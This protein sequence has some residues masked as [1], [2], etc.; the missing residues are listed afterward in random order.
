[1]VIENRIIERITKAEM[2]EGAIVSYKNCVIGALDLIGVFKLGSQ[3]SLENCIVQNLLI[4]S[5]WFDQGFSMKNCVVLRE[6][7]FQMGGHNAQPIIFDGNI[8]MEF[9][10]FFDCQF[11]EMIE[12]KHNIFMKG[13]NFLGNK[14]EGYEN[15]F[16]SG[17]LA[18]DNVGKIDLD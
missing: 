9:F 10:N 1:M 8:F 3:L 14:G 4:H 13:S 18:Q 16:D 11:H 6:V 15:T 5:C 2:N 12:V 17:F 7:D